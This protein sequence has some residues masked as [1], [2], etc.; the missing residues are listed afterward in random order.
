MPVPPGLTGLMVEME[1]TE[2]RDGRVKMDAT[3]TRGALRHLSNRVLD[4]H[5]LIRVIREDPE[6]SDY[7][8]DVDHRE[9]TPKVAAEEIR[10]TLD[11]PDAPDLM[12]H[13]AERFDRN[14]CSF[15]GST[16]S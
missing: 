2:V 5:Q 11:L 6:A 10:E 16:R 15:V 12:D 14:T 9:T 1:T 4:V 7:P 8:D 3:P 13:Q